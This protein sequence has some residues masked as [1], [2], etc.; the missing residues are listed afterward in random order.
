MTIITRADYL[1][2]STAARLHPSPSSSMTEHQRYFAQF[3]TD[4]TI[5]HVRQSFDADQLIK[6]F[7]ADPHLNTIPLDRWDAATWH[8]VNGSGHR[9]RETAAGNAGGPF[10]SHL[11]FDRDAIAA[12]GET[13]TRAVLVCIAKEAARQL[14]ASMLPFVMSPTPALTH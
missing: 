11:P 2:R 12:A 7:N 10:Y 6:A 1:K 8:N 14:V 4:K 9:S 3:V 13:V 5:A